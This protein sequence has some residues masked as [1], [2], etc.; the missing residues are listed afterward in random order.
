[1]SPSIRPPA[2][3]GSFY[4][5]DAAILSATVKDL[6]A[7]AAPPDE[8]GWPK[9]LIVPHAGYPYSGPIAASAYARLAAARGKV[10]R[11]VLLGPAHRVY[12]QGLALP[13]AEAFATPLGDIAVDRAA[14]AMLASLPQTSTLPAAH[15][16]EHALEVQLPFLQALL[17]NFSLVP[18]VVGATRPQEV[19]EVLELLWGGEETVFVVSSD[20]SH[21]LGYLEAQRVDR[22]TAEA[23]LQCSADLH[24]RQACGSGPLNGLLLAAKRRGLVPRLLDMRNSGD[25]AGDQ[26]RVVGY[27]AFALYES[28]RGEPDDAAEGELLLAHARHAISEHF[29][30]AGAPP[31]TPSWMKNR[32]ACFI[33]LKKQGELRGCI[34]TLEAHRTLEDDLRSNALAACLRDPRF[35]P[36]APDELASLRIEVSLLSSA[37]V[38]PCSGEDDAIAQLRPGIDGVILRHRERRATFLPQVWET[39]AQPRDFIAQL[40]RKAGLSTNFWDAEIELARYTVRKWSET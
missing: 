15:A 19:A 18:L 36:V 34:G 40:K 25:T 7:A 33:T 38:V 2:V 9:A 29:G 3:A 11:V 31:S 27:G 30:M 17:G 5:A 35:P 23:I 13:G 1:M 39:L 37:Q 12:V 20:L 14:L 4:P 22:A 10:T 16:A 32:G 28:Q 24:P 6:L 26:A 21:Y 8:A